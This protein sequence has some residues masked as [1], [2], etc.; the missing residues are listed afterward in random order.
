[1]SAEAKQTKRELY[2]HAL[3]LD[4]GSP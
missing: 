4:S 1:L 3:A 2:V